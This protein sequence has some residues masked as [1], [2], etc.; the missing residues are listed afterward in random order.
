MMAMYHGLR[1]HRKQLTSTLFGKEAGTVRLPSLGH[2]GIEFQEESDPRQVV[3]DALLRLGF[4]SPEELRAVYETP[5]MPCM[6]V[7]SRFNPSVSVESL[8]LEDHELLEVALVLGLCSK[9]VYDPA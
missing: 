8:F 7:P 4:Q 9:T 3:F 2:F 5:P 1:T 6:V